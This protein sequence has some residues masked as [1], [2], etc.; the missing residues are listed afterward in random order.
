MFF[1]DLKKELQDGVSFL[2]R[3]T[4]F[5]TVKQGKKEVIKFKGYVVKPLKK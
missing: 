3:L 4:S 2:I 5:V 1:D